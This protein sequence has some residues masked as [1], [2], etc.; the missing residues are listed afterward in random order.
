MGSAFF[1]L[2]FI[3][4]SCQT[5]SCHLEVLFGL[6][7]GILFQYI[8]ITT[9]QIPETGYFIFWIGGLSMELL[10]GI[11]TRKSTRAFKP[12][13]IPREVIEKI[14]EA[15]SNSPSYTNTQPWEVVVV[16]GQKKNELSKVMIELLRTKAPTSS[17]L[18]KP[19]DWPP[20]LEK[21]ASEHG[22]RRISTLGVSR[23]DQGGR[24]RLSQMNF[25][26]YGAPCAILLFM[27]GLLGE[28]SIFDMGL[29]A[30]NLILAAHSLGVGSC[31]QASV[32]GYSREIKN[33]LG[34]AESKKLIICIS[35]GY[36]D[37]KAELNTYRSIKQKLDEF[38]KWIE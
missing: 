24:E 20:A 15:V 33:I 30:Q 23:D 12:D 7:E 16:S 26:F 6:T 9:E 18:P 28:W 38:T 5:L 8:Q 27:D 31:L 1:Y 34:I 36:P 29:F 37:E 25:E 3:N 13:P 32:P 35:M 22:A 21:R 14:L 19:K 2:Y 17:D 11:K 4:E 10:E